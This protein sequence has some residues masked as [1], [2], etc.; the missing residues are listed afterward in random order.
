MNGM[1]L[2]CQNY[3]IASL[4]FEF[5]PHLL[6]MNIII[7]NVVN[8]AEFHLFFFFLT[9]THFLSCT[10][11]RAGSLLPTKIKLLLTLSIFCNWGHPNAQ[12]ATETLIYYVHGS[13]L[14]LNGSN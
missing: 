10:T 4:C 9:I 6:Q 3:P 5:H 14:S 11:T 13:S 8:I 2:M 12:H 1:K 7:I